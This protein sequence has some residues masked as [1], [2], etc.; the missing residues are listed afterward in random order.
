MEYRKTQLPKDFDTMK[1]TSAEKDANF[2]IV[3]SEGATMNSFVELKDARVWR[4]H[5]FYGYYSSCE[6]V[7]S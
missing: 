1:I 2:H 4:D 3:N 7:R 6:I 5:F